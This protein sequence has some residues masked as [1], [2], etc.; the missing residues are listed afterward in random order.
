MPDNKQFFI[1][2]A[3]K[4]WVHH[5]FEW[6]KNV[7][8]FPSPGFTPILFTADFFPKTIAHK[9][10]AIAPLLEDLCALFKINPS[11]ISFEMEEDIRDSH[12]IPY[13]LHGATFECDLEL[14]EQDN[15]YHYKFYFAKSLLKTPKRIL[16]NSVFYFIQ[17]RLSKTN[18]DWLKNEDH[19]FLFYLIG[20]YT[21]WGVVIAQTMTDVGK[22]ID[23]FWERSW[24]YISLMPVPVMAYSLALHASVLDEKDT[25][26]KNYLPP[27]IREQFEKAR[28][29]I[30]QN[31][32]PVFSKQEVTA[33]ALVEE[34]HRQSG[35]K[36]FDTAIETYQKAL[37]LANDDKFKALIH[38][39]IGYALLLKGEFQKGIVYFQKSLDL[40]PAFAY[41][42]ANLSFAF[43]MIGDTDTGKYYHTLASQAR[44]FVPSYS[45][46]N[47]ALYH[48][49]RGEIEL[50]EQNFQLAFEYITVPVDWLEYLYARFLFEQGE[51]NEALMYLQV[52][53]EKGEPR[54][55]QWM[56]EINES[57]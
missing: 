52:A 4:Q 36:D 22:K 25:L 30:R 17:I 3:D 12:G 28:E 47:L 55:I 14:I 32:N 39:N 7:Y 48:Q 45:Y 8:G 33:T 20:I 26:W 42:H 15:S 37:F 54:A 27:G 9:Q 35:Q 23:G 10:T 2:D 44:K 24:K 6:L 5:C 53:V 51:K 49:K 56:N 11:E 43:I 57:S 40:I 1:T 16:F 46:R 29:L 41:A 13:E 50:A 21:R 38:H 34:A 18:I 31:P 19:Y